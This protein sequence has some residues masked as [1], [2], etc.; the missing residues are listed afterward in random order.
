MKRLNLA[1]LLSLIIHVLGAILFVYVRVEEG[2]RRGESSIAVQFNVPT[3]QPRLKTEKPKFKQEQINRDLRSVSRTSSMRIKKIDRKMDRRTAYRDIIVT[4]ESDAPPGMEFSDGL[5]EG[6]GSYTI[7][8]GARGAGPN[9]RGGQSQLVEFVG[10]SR[11]DRTVIYCIDV[12]ASMGAANKLNLARNYMKD[13]LLALDAEKDSFNIIAFSGGTSIFRPGEPVP[14]TD[15]NLSDAMAFLDQYT[16][17]NIMSNTKTDLLSPLL[18][19]LEMNPTIIAM[20]TDG[21]PTT[22]V[23]NPE[24]I[25]QAISEGNMDGSVGIFAIGMEM[26]MDQ[27][28]AWLLRAIAEQNKGEFQFF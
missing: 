5:L 6:G 8:S 3:P 26:S 21:L 14:A 25:L 19:A 24:K 27:P 15:E 20:V 23:T 13:S 17:Q 1:F 9:V 4:D 22:G 11:G 2:V 18:Q 7:G 16:P 28:E 10:K 12:S